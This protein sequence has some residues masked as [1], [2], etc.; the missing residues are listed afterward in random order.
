[1]VMIYIKKTVIPT[2]C[3]KCGGKLT[4]VNAIDT[5]AKLYMVFCKSN[6]EKC[7]WC[8]NWK[9]EEL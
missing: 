5:E 7:R 8:K 1:M 3:P 9:L 6:P 2:L 4:H